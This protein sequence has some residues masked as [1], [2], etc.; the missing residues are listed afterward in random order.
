M[1]AVLGLDLGQAA[2]FSALATLTF[3]VEAI[4]REAKT[5][6]TPAW[7]AAYACRT[8]KRWPLGTTY[9]TIVAQVV[10][11]IRRCAWKK[12][13]LVVDATGVGR[14]VVDQLRQV[15]VP[16]V[17]VPVTI[18]GGRRAK[19]ADDGYCVPKKILTET[20][21]TLLQQRRLQFAATL[22]EAPALV[23]E[24]QRHCVSITSARHETF[25]AASGEHDDLVLALELATWWAEMRA[26]AP[27]RRQPGRGS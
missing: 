5:A 21:R 12:A 10:A 22:P 9:P 26:E 27:A 6:R 25:G 23:R 19:A 1:D 4:A 3:A 8:L 15:G 7:N 13:F 24:L 18:T 17:I 16:A 2:D 14:P 20:L 11:F